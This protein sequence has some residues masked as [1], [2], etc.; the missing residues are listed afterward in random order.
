MSYVKHYFPTV[1]SEPKTIFLSSI[2]LPCK[3]FIRLSLDM[4]GQLRADAAG[5]VCRIIL[6]AFQGKELA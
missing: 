6:N 4:I 2:L 5:R 1:S 3:H